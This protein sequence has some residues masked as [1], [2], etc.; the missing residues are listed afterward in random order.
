MKLKS[1][2]LAALAAFAAPAFAA[3]VIVSGQISAST[4]WTASNRYQLQ[5]KVYVVGGATLT[6]EAG[7]VIQ[8]RVSSGNDAAALVITRGSRIM[9]EGTPTRPIIFTS[10][11]DQLN[12]NLTARD[13][14]LWGGVV[15][16]GSAS[17][18]SRAD[19]A[20]VPAPVTDQIE[21]IA[22]VN[23]D[24]LVAGRVVD[25]VLTDELQIAVLIIRAIEA[26]AARG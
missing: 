25:V 5:G 8:G 9:A 6:I 18:N 22:G 20:V 24:L 15:I 23:G 21:G 13:V 19:S 12:G 11:L 2:L 4:T 10:E 3:D 7:T 17:I 26:H 14:G 1:L 16:L